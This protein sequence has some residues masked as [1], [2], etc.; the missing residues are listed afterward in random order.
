MKLIRAYVSLYVR[1]YLL[2]PPLAPS[3]LIESG[4]YGRCNILTVVLPEVSKQ[5]MESLF[6]ILSRN[7]GIAGK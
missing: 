4:G 3:D 5:V 1:K 7:R 2:L 6:E